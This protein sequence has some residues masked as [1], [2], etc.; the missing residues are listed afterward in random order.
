MTLYYASHI[1][2]YCQKTQNLDILVLLLLLF[3]VV[4]YRYYF[5]DHAYHYYCDIQIIS[6]SSYQPTYIL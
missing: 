6:L 5:Y 3:L 2:Y 1:F 4:W